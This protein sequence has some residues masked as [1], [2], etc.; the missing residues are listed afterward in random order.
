MAS[1]E[2]KAMTGVSVVTRASLMDPAVA[3]GLLVEA[4]GLAAAA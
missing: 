2:A 4:Q 3:S 1:A